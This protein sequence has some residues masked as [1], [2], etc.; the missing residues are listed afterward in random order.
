MYIGE[1][2]EMKTELSNKKF[3]PRPV[4]FFAQLFFGCLGLIVGCDVFNAK[5]RLAFFIL[6]SLLIISILDLLICF[7]STILWWN[8]PL[9]FVEEGIISGKRHILHRWEDA[10]EFKYKTKIVGSS[11]A[12]RLYVLQIVYVEGTKVVIERD[13]LEFFKKW[14]C[15]FCPNANFIEKYNLLLQ[16]TALWNKRSGNVAIK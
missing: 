13:N 6:L 5:N 4:L 10:I 11:S 3:L 14:F 1:E 16:D 15:K 8:I 12:S 7:L 9:K 2:E